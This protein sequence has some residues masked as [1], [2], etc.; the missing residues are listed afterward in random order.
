MTPILVP[1]T[2]TVTKRQIVT[3]TPIELGLDPTATKF[4]KKSVEDAAMLQ[5]LILATGLDI[6][7]FGKNG[8]Q[9]C[10]VRH[11]V[12]GGAYLFVDESGCP[13]VGVCFGEMI[14]PKEAAIMFIEEIP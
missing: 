12:E 9:V 10:A 11:W 1:F 2:P 3:K 6:H 8:E 7:H 13:C 14:F 4:S 5:G